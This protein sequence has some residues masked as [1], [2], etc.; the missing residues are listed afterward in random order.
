M[1]TTL[2]TCQGQIATSLRNFLTESSFSDVTLV[3]GDSAQ[4]QAHKAVLSS[5]SPLLKELLLSNPQ[6][7]QVVSLPDIKQLELE[8]ILEFIYLGQ[9]RV[10][11][12]Q[13]NSFLKGAK[14]LQIYDY[15]RPCMTEACEQKIYYEDDGS[16]VMENV[17]E[18]INV[19]LEEEV[20]SK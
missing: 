2:L 4:F 8:A 6:S 18:D 10:Y 9:A 11:P 1:A 19:D 20:G 12:A 17:V 7:H 14:A 15:I 13:I 16:I 5:V 3:C